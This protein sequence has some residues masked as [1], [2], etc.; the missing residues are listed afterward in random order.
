MEEIATYSSKSDECWHMLG[1]TL[2]DQYGYDVE[3]TE[4]MIDHLRKIVMEGNGVK[5]LWDVVQDEESTRIEQVE[6]WQWLL[7]AELETQSPMV[8]EYS[9][10]E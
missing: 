3:E 2:H 8:N 5:E 9:R 1:E 10:L 4:E 6:V 7:K